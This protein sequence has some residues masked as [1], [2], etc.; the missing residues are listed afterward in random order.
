MK[1]FLTV[2]IGMVVATSSHALPI[3]R[4]YGG[5]VLGSSIDEVK[6][7]S[8]E[9]IV[10][11]LDKNNITRCFGKINAFSF[12]N[13]SLI[14]FLFFIDGGLSKFTEINEENTKKYGPPKIKEE[15][16]TTLPGT[17]LISNV[18]LLEWSDESTKFAL[19]YHSGVN[20]E[21]KII[22]N[23]AI[24]LSE[25]EASIN[26][27]ENKNK[28]TPPSN[29]LS[30]GNSQ[31]HEVDD[32][33]KNNLYKE[34]IIKFKELCN[35]IDYTFIKKLE[36]VRINLSI[37]YGIQFDD[38]NNSLIRNW[39][40]SFAVSVKDIYI[41]PTNKIAQIKFLNNVIVFMDLSGIGVVQFRWN[42]DKYW[43][44]K[45]NEIHNIINDNL[46]VSNNCL[47]LIEQVHGYKIN[48]IEEA[49][50]NDF[51]ENSDVDKLTD[52]F[53]GFIDSVKSSLEK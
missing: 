4:Q 48:I 33:N 49:S 52:K 41:D 34:K 26:S 21:G 20:T 44:F 24:M 31:N 23:T 25:T 14:D 45:K 22:D 39:N 50:C 28:P 10:C 53:K 27:I 36:H 29:N 17:Q 32:D 5:F 1:K 43:D 42:F 7:K 37:K 19:Q 47:I 6:H 51:V 8:H 11:L 46:N 40:D 9:K 18:K 3:D 35:L 30:N 38:I 2:L 13:N 15:S 12:K 16:K